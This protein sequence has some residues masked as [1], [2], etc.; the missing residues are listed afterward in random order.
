MTRFATFNLENL[1]SRPVAM[2]RTSDAIG[3][4]VLPDFA[5]LNSIVTKPVYT[6]EDKNRLVQLSLK[7]G[8]HHANQ[9]DPFIRLNKIRGYLFHLTVATGVVSVVADGGNAW[10]G[11]FY[12]V[13]EDV[14]WEAT[15]NTGRV[16]STVNPDVLICVE[17]EDR[18]TLDRFNEQVL[19]EQF[20]PTAAYP[21]VLL[22]DGNDSR[23]IDI[24]ILSRHEVT[25]IRS[26]LHEPD[27][28]TGEKLFS[29]DCPEFEIAINGKSVIILGNHFKSKRSGNSASSA[30]KRQRQAD[31][32]KNIYTAAL[33]RSDL[34]LV[35]GDLN[36]TPTSGPI[37]AL[38]QGLAAAKKPK[39]VMTSTLYT[40]PY[41]GTFGTGLASG[42]ID[43]LFLSPA[44]W[45]D[46]DS[47]GIE[48]RGAY[49]PQKWTAFDT[50]TGE[51]NQAADHACLWA[52]VDV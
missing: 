6:T 22:I 3:R 39:D 38:T 36:D 17:V 45:A 13:R 14:V 48:R 41:P 37:T 24:G 52:D 23:G 33:T 29:R 31:R 11:W 50:V 1:F 28:I 35:G 32:V 30:A 34:V 16:I 8:F 20:G 9:T 4:E 27:P 5:E 46:L 43:Y 51:N 15:Y 19:R 47:V 25:S 21:H 12:L 10:T 7:Y 2:N 18:L 42:K 26:H 44:L 40:D 49:H